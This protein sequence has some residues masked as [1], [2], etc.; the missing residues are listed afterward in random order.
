MNQSIIKNEFQIEKISSFS[1][2]ICYYIKTG[3]I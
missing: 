2:Y 1:A 3:T